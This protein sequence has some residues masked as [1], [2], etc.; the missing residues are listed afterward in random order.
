MGRRL[1]ILGASARAAAFSAVR[2]GFEPHAID[3]FAD[4]DLAELCPAVRIERYPLDFVAALA[5]LPDAQWMYTGGLENYPRL[6]ARMAAMRP[7][8]GNSGQTLRAVR[9]PQLLNNVLREEGFL[10]PCAWNGR[11]DAGRQWLVK[12]RRGSGGLGVRFATTEDLAAPSRGALVQ[13]YIEGESAS[14]AFVA[15]N[16]QAV[17]L[18]ATRQLIGRDWNLWPQFVYLGSIRPLGLTKEEQACLQRLGEVLA[19][20]F[21]LVGL[22][23]VDF[24]R[25]ADALWPVEVNPRYAASME[26]LERIAGQQLIGFHVAACERGELPAAAAITGHQCAGKAVAYAHSEC[27]WSEESLSNTPD[28]VAEKWPDIADLP[29]IGQWF[30]A[31]QPIATVFASGSSIAEVERNLRQRETAVLASLV[32]VRPAGAAG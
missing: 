17:L 29:H 21:G 18:G 2:A 30:H 5:E 24:V 14:A 25:A 26:V 11:E 22:F 9:N 16:G 3:L 20:R 27:S 10:C 28:C 31:G 23:G 15:A 19:R 7:L 1:I 12:P 13:E 32:T 8:L 4:R 6:I